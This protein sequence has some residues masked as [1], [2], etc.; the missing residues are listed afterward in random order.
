M[1]ECTISV[2]C[3]FSNSSSSCLH[4][5]TLPFLHFIIFLQ[6]EIAAQISMLRACAIYRV[7]EI[8]KCKPANCIS[9]N[10]HPV[11]CL[12][13]ETMGLFFY[14]FNGTIE[15]LCD[16][17]NEYKA[18]KKGNADRK[19]KFLAKMCS[20]VTGTFILLVLNGARIE[21]QF[22]ISFSAKDQS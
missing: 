2:I 12:R 20:K 16:L 7:N 3:S 11:R 9:Q 8:R 6:L 10:R 4:L 13:K 5:C 15:P 17:I 21:I 19:L 14:Y 22:N 18:L 1:I